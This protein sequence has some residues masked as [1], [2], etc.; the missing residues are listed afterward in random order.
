MGGDPLGVIEKAGANFAGGI[1]DVGVEYA[2]E[3]AHLQGSMRRE[4]QT[5]HQE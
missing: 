1:V 2:G 3:T 4:G 5:Q